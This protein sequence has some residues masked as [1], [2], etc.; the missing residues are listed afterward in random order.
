MAGVIVA[1]VLSLTINQY[2]LSVETSARAE[3]NYS[4][5]RAG[6]VL[7]AAV[8]TAEKVEWQASNLTVTYLTSEGLEKDQ[9]YLADK[10]KDGQQDLYR[11]HRNIPNPVATFLTE[12]NCEELKPGL[13]E[14]KLQAQIK[15]QELLWERRV[16]QKCRKTD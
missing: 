10:D 2:R 16:R 11:E 13:W 6:Q 3:M 5:L 8:K 4:L 12:F 7:A 14:I 1:G 15:E 9:F